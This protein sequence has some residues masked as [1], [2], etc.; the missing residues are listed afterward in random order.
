MK[1]DENQSKDTVLMKHLAR[2][3]P[4]VYIN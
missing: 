4:E 1:K 2:T 3:K